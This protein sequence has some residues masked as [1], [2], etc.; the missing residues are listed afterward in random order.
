MLLQVPLQSQLV[1]GGMRR[2]GNFRIIGFD[3]ALV[4]GLG[5][6]IVFMHLL[7]HAGQNYAGD[8]RPPL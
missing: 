2:C 1:P 7:A 3:M 4:Q 6:Q 5:D 8:R